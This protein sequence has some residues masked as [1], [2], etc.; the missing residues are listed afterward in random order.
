MAEHAAIADMVPT[1]RG[2]G[3]HLHCL[4]PQ[5]YQLLQLASSSITGCE[6]S[7]SAAP[8]TA[9][10]EGGR[11]NSVS[12]SG[13]QPR[14]H[15]RRA[16]SIHI[17]LRKTRS[18]SRPVNA[19]RDS[20]IGVS[21]DLGVAT[22]VAEGR[23]PNTRQRHGSFGSASGA[24]G[25]AVSPTST[26]TVT[27]TPTGAGGAAASSPFTFPVVSGCV[28]PKLTP[29]HHDAMS[30]SLTVTA[31]GAH[32]APLFDDVANSNNNPNSCGSSRIMN[33]SS[34]T[35]YI[36][37]THGRSGD[38]TASDSTTAAAAPAINMQ[39]TGA[40]ATNVGS[41]SSSMVGGAGGSS[42]SVGPS[43][44]SCVPTVHGVGYFNTFVKAIHPS[45]M[46][47]ALLPPNMRDRAVVLGMKHG[48][49]AAEAMAAHRRPF[50]SGA[51]SRRS[52]SFSGNHGRVHHH[53]S[54]SRA[55]AV[56]QR[57]H[58]SGYSGG[59]RSSSMSGCHTAAGIYNG[60]N[61]SHRHATATH[62]LQDCA[63]PYPDS[64]S[65]AL[66]P[67]PH[68]QQQPGHPPTPAWRGHLSSMPTVNLG[69]SPRLSP[70]AVPAAASDQQDQHRRHYRARS[71]TVGG[72]VRSSS[73]SSGGGAVVVATAADATTPNA[74]GR[75]GY[76][77]SAP[78]PSPNRSVSLASSSPTAAAPV[79]GAVATTAAGQCSRTSTLIHHP[80]LSR[81]G[82]SVET[83]M[84]AITATLPPASP[85]PAYTESRASS[86]VTGTMTP[87]T[88]RP[89]NAAIEA[90]A[91]GISSAQ[92][93]I[94][95]IEHPSHGASSGQQRSV[96]SDIVNG[97][98]D[99]VDSVR[100]G[101]VPSASNTSAANMM[102]SASGTLDRYNYGGATAA[103]RQG[104]TAVFATSHRYARDSVASEDKTDDE[105]RRH[106]GPLRRYSTTLTNTTTEDEDEPQ[107]QLAQPSTLELLRGNHLRRESGAGGGGGNVNVA[108][109]L[110]R[111]RAARASATG[112][113]AAGA[114]NRDG[115]PTTAIER[116]RAQEQQR[117][118]DEERQ[119]QR[120]RQRQRLSARQW[121]EAF[122]RLQEKRVRW[123]M[124][125]YIGRGTSG[126]V[127]E[128][129]LEDCKQTPV[130]VKVLEVGVPIPVDLDTS[131]DDNDGQSSRQARYTENSGAPT[132]AADAAA[133][134]AA[135]MSPSQQ[136]A[137]LVLLREV[138]MMEKLHHDNIVTCLRCQV[139]PVQDRYLELHQ[140]QQ[141]Q[142][143][144]RD[145]GSNNGEGLSGTAAAGRDSEEVGKRRHDSAGRHYVGNGKAAVC[146]G[147]FS[148]SQS[149][150][151]NAA[152]RIPVQVEIVMELC[153]RG[154]ISSVVRR[155]P[156]GQLPVRVAR[157]YLRDVLKGLAYLHRNNFIHRDVKGDNVLISAADV[158]K[159]ADFGCSRRIVLTNNVHGA[160]DSEGGTSSIATTRT[161]ATDSRFTTMAE[162]QWFDTTGVAQTMVGTPMFMAPEI[163]QASGPPCMTTP[164][165]SSPASSTFEGNDG[166][167][168]SSSKAT[169]PPAPVG[170]TASADI[171]SFGCLV[172]E[173]FGRTPW[174]ASGGNAYH[175]MKQIEQSVADLPP[176]V[177]DGTPAELLDLLRCCFHRDPHRRSTAR[178]L[179]RAPWMTCKDEELEE[180]PPRR[181]Y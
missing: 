158:A 144:C 138:E 131:G 112:A 70:S 167:H 111:A 154:T 159:L 160:A 148:A 116:W 74:S 56:S 118:R 14:Q 173:V 84:T 181:R 127:Y 81:E 60:K 92:R 72:R 137:L 147:V 40:A 133:A 64:A 9:G 140:Q 11:I 93:G 168:G 128:G 55:Q 32:R 105:G 48:D 88:P 121:R 49:Q 135:C 115:S 23:T 143:Q 78:S 101:S 134:D 171:W 46:K 2:D 87:R 176:G 65:V 180:M 96:S 28:S 21:R 142:Q 95:L 126:V 107:Q 42:S 174:P 82:S 37:H 10:V 25:D 169:P 85:L 50:S 89:A 71:Y 62:G 149:P 26:A 119:Q 163:I 97:L 141:Q 164:T 162:Y 15:Y 139:T 178:A 19:Q 69:T 166:G 43:S 22:G 108:A 6:T 179:L 24:L 73:S 41:S 156:G 102:G 61:S 13:A 4:H 117:K 67:Q 54:V 18:G 77:D 132:S 75:V 52:S 130:A 124:R 151:R 157:R 100:C 106:R 35:P 113:A 125:G 47:Q 129:V 123:R 99:S 104:G 17:T 38:G 91:A 170:Y 145:G 94:R 39:T 161:A 3:R 53:P 57:S 8:K 34:Y 177:P 63:P 103:S 90:A 122:H 150:Q 30:A 12:G 1:S 66:H 136:E 51:I 29:R 98:D 45:D 165:A 110:S 86:A 114:T 68:Q 76:V 172:L 80:S 152:P 36:L 83:T 59:L 7:H 120:Q 20:S 58:A 175:L 109:V 27:G 146:D 153:N 33:S 5:R 44:G 155:S 79:F 16:R 31:G